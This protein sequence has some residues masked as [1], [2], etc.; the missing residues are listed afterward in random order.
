MAD[1]FT[2]LDWRGDLT[3]SERALN[4]IDGVILARAAYFP[5]A[6]ILTPGD[7]RGMRLADAARAFEALENLPQ[8]VLRADDVRLIAALRES[9]RFAELM[10]CAYADELDAPTQTQFSAVTFVLPDGARVVSFRGTDSTLIGWKEDFNMGFVCPVPA[11]TLAVSY[12]ED[13]A[14][15]APDAPLYVVGHSKGGNLAVYA[16]AFCRE[17]VQP[18]IRT[19]YNY[20][21][22]GFD[23]TVLARDGYRHIRERVRT[24]VPL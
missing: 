13:I 16:A 24:Y 3:F 19:V 8:I 4:P 20:D 5:Y 7:M 12:L 9:A 17:E 23:Q 15:R 21:G 10:V 1:L 11:Q 18:R 22:P 2:Y 6:K 14:A